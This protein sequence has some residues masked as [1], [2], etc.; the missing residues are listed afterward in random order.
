MFIGFVLGTFGGCYLRSVGEL[1][2]TV[3]SVHW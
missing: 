3:I 1:V 2:H